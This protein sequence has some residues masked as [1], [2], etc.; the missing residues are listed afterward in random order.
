MEM[1]KRKI[2]NRRKDIRDY[3]QRTLIVC[4]GARTEPNYFDSFPKDESKY[5]VE[6]VGTGYNTHSLVRRAIEIQKTSIQPFNK[7]WC[8]FD[9]DG[10]N[11][12]G[13]PIENFNKAFEIARDN[14]IEIAYSNQAFEI[15]YLLHFNYYDSALDRTQYCEKLSE[16]LGQ[17]YEKND[18]D[19]YKK[20]IEKQPKAIENAKRLLKFHF[21]DKGRNDPAK[22]NPSTTVY[23]L[24][25]ELN[26]M[27]SC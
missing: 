25:E 3:R 18:R 24:V 7:I 10:E 1:S 26:K 20:L 12:R 11:N 8:V 2:S 17:K 27:L 14:G 22:D 9:R 4:E 13:F 15:W 23:K 16:L 6:P 5:Y 19:M 21:E